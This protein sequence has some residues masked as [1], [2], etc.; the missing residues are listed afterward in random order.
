MEQALTIARLGLIEFIQDVR[1]H[2][3]DWHNLLSQIDTWE[4]AVAEGIMEGI[5]GFADPGYDDD[6]GFSRTH[7]EYS[8]SGRGPLRL[9]TVVRVSKATEKGSY[10]YVEI[11]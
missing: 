4:A 9:Y 7:D 3:L 6:C 8:F 2:K 5:W 10:F 1:M 11:D